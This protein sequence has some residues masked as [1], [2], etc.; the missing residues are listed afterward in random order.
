MKKENVELGALK[1]EQNEL[2]NTYFVKRTRCTWAPIA[3]LAAA[4]LLS[5]C[6][7][8]IKE[9]IQGAV[10]RFP[11]P[12]RVVITANASMSNLVVK[13]VTPNSTNNVQVPYVSDKEY[14]GNVNL[15]VGNHTITAEADVYCWY[16]SPP[17]QHSSD[18]KNICVAADTWLSSY[19]S[20]TAVGKSNNLSWSK[21]SDTAVGVAADTGASESRWNL[22]R[23]SRITQRIGLIQSTENS[24]LCMRS[25]DDNQRTPIGLAI[26]DAHDRTQLWEAFEMPNTNGNH[27]FQNF[28]RSTSSACLTQDSANTLIQSSCL[29]TDNQLWKIKDNRTGNF[30]SPF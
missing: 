19:P 15:P 8:T 1:S 11:A 13:D 21:T 27:R 20:Y 6:S 3:M 22:I 16:C 24:C 18:Q 2:V 30:V 29:D 28:G 14:T 26:C 23:A 9:P 4:V 12:V 25:M 7:I 10:I 17:S 5:G